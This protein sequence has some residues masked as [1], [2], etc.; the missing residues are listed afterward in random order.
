[1]ATLLSWP[2]IE[3]GDIDVFMPSPPCLVV[4]TFYVDD[5]PQSSVIYLWQDQNSSLLHHQLLF[6]EPVGFETALAWA[7]E[8]APKRDVQRIHV[9]HAR[10]RKATAKPEVQKATVKKRVVKKARPAKAI[11]IRKRATSAKGE[12]V[13]DQGVTAGTLRHSVRTFCLIQCRTVGAALL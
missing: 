9:R 13:D 7:Q 5:Q 3:I 6:M 12:A 10:A 11:P 2:S 4:Y 1:M 8:H